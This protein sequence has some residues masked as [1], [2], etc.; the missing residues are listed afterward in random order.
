MSETDSDS[1]ILEYNNVYPQVS[2]S[3]LLT[4]RPGFH[5]Q[6]YHNLYCVGEKHMRCA[7]SAFTLVPGTCR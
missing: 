2:C 4:L 5:C 3:I 1:G 6:A 7:F